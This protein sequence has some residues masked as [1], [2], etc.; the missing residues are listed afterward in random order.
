LCKG[1]GFRYIFFQIP[2]LLGRWRLILS[3][4]KMAKFLALLV[5]AAVARATVSSAGQTL[6]VNGVSYY[7]APEAVTI[8]SAT[9]DMLTTAARGTDVD[10]IPLTVMVDS[11]SQFTT[12]VFRSVVSN[13]TSSDDVFNT[14]FLQCLFLSQLPASL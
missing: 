7:A 8:I 2:V 5:F 11:S 1:G 14:G 9:A 3:D 13:Y 12:D 6:V 4:I 10:L